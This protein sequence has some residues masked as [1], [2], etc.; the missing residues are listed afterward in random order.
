MVNILFYM[1]FHSKQ[2]NELNLQIYRH[3]IVNRAQEECYYLTFFPA[4]HILSFYD[5]Y[6]SEKLDKENEEKCK[7]LIRFVNSKV[8]LPSHKDAK[9]ILRGSEDYLEI[10]YK[11]GNEL[12]RIFGNIPKQPR[13]LAGQR[14]MSDI[15]TTGKLFVASCT[16][17]TRVPNIIM[18]LYANHGYYPEPWQL[19]MCTSSTTM[20]E[21]TIFIKR[22]FFASNNGYDNHLFC[23]AS[24]ELLDFELQSYLVNQIKSMRNQKEDY[25][26]ALICCGETGMHHHILDQFSLDAQATNGLNTE[27]M[28]EIYREL[29]QNVTRVSSNLSGQ[30]K[31]EWI[32]QTS[33]GKKKILRSFLIRDDMDFG[34]LVCQFKEC[35]LRPTESLHINIVSSDHPGD[36]N[37]FLFELLTMGMVYTNVDIACLPL[38]EA[39][40]HIFIEIASTT[41]QH[42]LN[43]LPMAGYLLFNHLTWNIKNMKISQEIQSPIQV[44]CHYLDLLDRNEMDT[45]E[46]LF[47]PDKAINEPLPAERCQSLI[48]KYFFNKNAENVTSFRFVEI[49]VNVLADQLDRFSSSQFLD[50]VELIV[51]ETNIRT[52]LLKTLIDVSKD[53]ATRS[54]K[55]KAAQLESVT[56]DDENVHF[57]TITQWDDSNHLIIFFNS[58]ING[59]ISALYRDRTKV[60][61]DIKILLKSQV[62]GD[63][64]EWELEDYNSMSA[65][66]ILLKLEYLA[67]RSMEILKLPEYALSGDNLIKMAL[68]LLRVR[69]NIPVI[70]CGEAG[71]GKVNKTFY[72]NY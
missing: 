21:L 13:K 26:L 40:T 60:H 52:L 14:V 64:A 41:N 56:A 35:K 2:I 66:A 45:K 28:R 39:N 68:I 50:N 51:K 22:S 25:L 18:S 3:G 72:L 57:G 7:T 65:N 11:I 31:T 70:I 37:M 46:I 48:S 27:S 19:L 15:V 53:F 38:P 6:I 12:K 9:G 63:Q 23:I 71:C 54:V 16:D 30:G 17:Q 33:F 59:T 58:Q 36:V 10:L 61:D 1:T 44:T 29:C 24:V 4:R 5:Y 8:K 62:I 20:E 34:R 47:W 32:K 43:S 49:F 69:A 67:R 42:L 55:T